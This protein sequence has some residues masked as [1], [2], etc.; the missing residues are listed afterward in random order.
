MSNL[1]PIFS[2]LLESFVSSQK[3]IAEITA[4]GEKMNKDIEQKKQDDKRYLDPEL[5]GHEA[6]L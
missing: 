6:E 2:D 4:R 3:T 5:T 1:H